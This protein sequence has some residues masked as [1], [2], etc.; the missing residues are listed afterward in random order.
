MLLIVNPVNVPTLVMLGCAA[1]VTVCEYIDSNAGGNVLPAF[2][3]VKFAMF[4]T[5]VLSVTGVIPLTATTGINVPDV[6]LLPILGSCVI[7]IVV[8]AIF[9]PI[10]RR[11]FHCYQYSTTCCSYTV[12]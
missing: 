11:L 7:F 2:V 4:P 6:K 5:V 12:R 10:I 3:N 1:F 8:F 9:Y